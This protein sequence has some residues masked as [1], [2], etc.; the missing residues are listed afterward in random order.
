MEGM[1]TTLPGPTVSSDP[2][3]AVE[4]ARN[5]LSGS[6]RGATGR[7]RRQQRRLA[8]VVE[9]AALRALTFALTDEVL[10]FDDD[11]RAAARFRAIVAE[12]G[13]PAGLGPFDRL[14]LRLGVP[15]SRLLPR[16]VMPLVR[17]RIVRE[18]NGVV[19]EADDPGFARH[20]ARRTAE[21]FRLNVNVLGEAILSDA[22][23]DDRMRQLRERIA[24]PDVTYVSLK[25]SAVVANLDVLAFEHSVD[26]ICDR[27]RVLYR[28]AQAAS[29]RTFV[30]LDME[31]Y[32]DLPLTLA[33]L[34]RVLDEPEFE[35]ID[36]GVVLQAYLQ[37]GRAHV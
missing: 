7:E 2:V 24:R 9:D 26:R 25:I 23:A 8:A 35:G 17:G 36:A 16:L 12:V 34:R 20:V 13:V 11:R 30:N 15:T 37:I 21:G 4:Q 6:L 28:D 5:L 27:L 32:R 1:T 3:A 18:S 22:E 31:E 29:P 10:R 33:S 14:L 19:L